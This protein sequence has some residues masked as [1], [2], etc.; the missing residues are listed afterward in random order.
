MDELDHMSHALALGRRTMGATGKNP[1]VGCVLVK[2]GR[3][4]G[5]GWTQEGGVPHAET[6]ALRMAGDMAR[7]AT[8][9]VSLEPCSHHGRTAPCAEALVAAGIERVVTAIEDPDPRVKGA[10]H[11][12]LRAAGLKVDS[13]LLA[14]EARRDLS[15]FLSRITR[16]RPHVLLKL[17]CSS[18][19]MIAE[20][21]GQR[22]SITGE[23][24]KF[25]T[26]LMRAKADAIM[27]GI[28]TVRADDPHLTCRLPGLEHRSPVPVVVDGGLTIEASRKLVSAAP[29]RPLLILTTT[30]AASRPDL[31]AKGVEIIRCRSIEPGRLDLDHGLEQ[32][33]RRGIGR[34]LVEGGANLARQLIDAALVD[35]IALYRSPRELGGQ[36]VP[37]QLD[38]GGFQRT[39]EESLGADVLTHYEKC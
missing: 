8:A 31:E 35:E 37:A 34:L 28:R 4:I 23:E 3:V 1:A 22:T 32:L 30:D 38:L 15:G 19:G 27:V 29:P 17:A 16:G 26:H 2:D 9:Y 20:A 5:T 39:A 7:G 14:E 6:E 12:R 10:G 13:G 21:P 24:A 18:D 11:A 33:A 25:R 36:G